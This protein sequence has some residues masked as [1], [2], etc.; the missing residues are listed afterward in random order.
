[1]KIGSDKMTRRTTLQVWL[2]VLYWSTCQWKGSRTRKAIAVQ[3]WSL[4][5]EF[6][7]QWKPV[8]AKFNMQ[9]VN[10]R[11]ADNVIA[12]DYASWSTLKYQKFI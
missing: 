6:D 10:Q 4:P 3:A 12:E 7:D 8:R 2:Q 5:G 9:L 11:G 1:M